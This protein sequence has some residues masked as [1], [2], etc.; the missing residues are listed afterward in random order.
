MTFGCSNQ[1]TA[2]AAILSRFT[3]TL[4]QSINPLPAAFLAVALHKPV[5]SP[6]ATDFARVYSIFTPPILS[7]ILPSPIGAS[8]EQA[9]PLESPDE[10]QRLRARTL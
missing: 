1:A 6:S 2:L 9:G 4:D 7:L 8:R 3:G 5:P 10:P